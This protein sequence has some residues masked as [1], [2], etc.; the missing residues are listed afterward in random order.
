LSSLIETHRID[1]YLGLPTFMGRS[2]NQAFNYI[3]EQ[4]L[5]RLTNRKVNFLSQAVKE[6]LLKAAVQAIPTYCMGVFQQPISL[7]KEINAI[8]QS[9]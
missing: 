2:R 6:V 9:F 3:K 4:V 8:M 7:C 5:H 1:A